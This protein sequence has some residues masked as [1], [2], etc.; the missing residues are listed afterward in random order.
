MYHHRQMEIRF[1]NAFFD[2]V[3]NWASVSE[4]LVQDAL[5]QASNSGLHAMDALHVAAARQTSSL[6]IVTTEKLT[7]PIHRIATVKVVPLA[8]LR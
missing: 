4:Q 2:K 7:K 1:Y 8:S 3:T 5:L 6:E